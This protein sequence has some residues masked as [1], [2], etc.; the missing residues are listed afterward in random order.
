MSYNW[1]SILWYAPEGVAY[2]VHG[3]SGYLFRFDPRKPKIEIVERITSEPSKKSGMFDKYYFGYLGFKLGPDKHTIYY[4]TGGPI[5]SDGQ[6]TKGAKG[7]PYGL[8]GLENMHLI[9]YNIPDRKYMDHGPIFYEDGSRPT[10]V[11][12]IAFG[13]DGYVYTLAQIDLN[14]KEDMV[15]IPDP[16]AK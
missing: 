10:W 5:N 2:G 4:L 15:K 3:S 7:I 11:N 16:L 9:T 13:K 12:S 14:E 1:R 8:T 6:N